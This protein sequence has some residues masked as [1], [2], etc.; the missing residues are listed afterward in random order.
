[1]VF[2]I[3]DDEE[4]IRNFLYKLGAARLDTMILTET[5]E[6][7]RNFVFSIPHDKILGLNSEIA[8]I[9]IKNL[10]LKFSKYGILF[11]YVSIIAIRLP[12]E[13]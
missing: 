8:T 7:I 11:E 5:D 3:K 6:A 10:N 9:M 13:I 2:K 4:S 1:M 12:W